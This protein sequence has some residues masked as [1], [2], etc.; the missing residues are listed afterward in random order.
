MSDKP[1]RRTQVR[2][3]RRE[4]GRA[5]ERRKNK[6]KLV[7]ALIAAAFVLFV[8][9]ATTWYARSN[10]SAAQADGTPR[11]QVDHDQIDLGLQPLNRTVRAAFNIKN[12]G[13][14]TLKLDVPRVAT[15]LEGC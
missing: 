1:M 14:G 8:V 5:Q 9:A 3:T 12:T 2:V 15:L 11:L 6:L 10:P 7:V 13:D 4:Q